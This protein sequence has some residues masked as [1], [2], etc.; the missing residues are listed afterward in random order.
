MNREYWWNGNRQRN[1]D[2]LRETWPTITSS[3]TNLTEPRT[4]KFL[5]SPA[6]IWIKRTTFSSLSRF[7]IRT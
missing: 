4:K 1:I 5:V 7:E 2:V 3:T 6:F